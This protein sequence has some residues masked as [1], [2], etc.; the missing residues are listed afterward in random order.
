MKNARCQHAPGQCLRVFT[1]T[2]ITSL[3]P[4][5]WTQIVSIALAADP[6]R[7]VGRRASEPT[8]G[9]RRDKRDESTRG[10]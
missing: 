7:S 9:G 1:D 8:F 10:R 2:L 4:G 6:A 3:L 5:K